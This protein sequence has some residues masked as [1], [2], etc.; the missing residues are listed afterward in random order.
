MPYDEIGDVDDQRH[1]FREMRMMKRTYRLM[2]VLFCLAIAGPLFGQIPSDRDGLLAGDAMGQAAPA[3]LN[4]CPSPKRVM[5]LAKELKLSIGQRTA[6]EALNR[7][8][9]T[10]AT[11]LGK[12]IV[13]VEE[14][15]NDAFKSG[16][17][18]EKSI[19]ETT[20][21]I[22]K[23]RGKLRAIHLA[24]ALKMRSTLTAEQFRVCAGIKIP[25]GGAKK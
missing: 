8:L 7:D 14:E 12:R 23:L 13:A 19:Q 20:D 15:L 18:S 11:D 5:D 4:G 24:A 3:E 2:A 17:V 1:F 9:K 21:Q 16:L 22:A 6:V 25:K 10:R